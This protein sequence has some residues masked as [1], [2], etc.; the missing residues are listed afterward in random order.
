MNAISGSPY[1]KRDAPYI[2]TNTNPS[3][4]SLVEGQ[5][6]G[7]RLPWQVTVDA[8]VNKIFM[9]DNKNSFE[10]YVQ[11]LNLFNKY[12][13]TNV[14]PFTGSP[15]DD[16]YLASPAAQA[17]LSDQTSA[18]AFVDLYNRRVVNP[19]NYGLPRRIRL[20]LVYNF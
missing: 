5:I 19:F 11:I 14:Y 4:V 20:G 9:L 1:T 17:S 7:S 18:Q 12:N 13:V 16:G 3:S 15:D 6:N 10:V 2:V 8:R